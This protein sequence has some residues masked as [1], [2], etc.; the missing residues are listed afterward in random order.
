MRATSSNNNIA[1]ITCVLTILWVMPLSAAANG[2]WVQ[3]HPRRAE[4][5]GRLANQNRRIFQERREGE[6]SRGQALQLHV[7]NVL[8]QDRME[9][10]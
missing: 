5:N 9:A 7:R 4:V 2:H 8:W 10:I 1:A 3:N 6:I